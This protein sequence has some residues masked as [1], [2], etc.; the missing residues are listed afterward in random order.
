MRTYMHTQEEGTRKEREKEKE[1]GNNKSYEVLLNYDSQ[2]WNS[3]KTKG[4]RVSKKE[5]WLY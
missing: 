3:D 4:S 2:I 5:L 1:R